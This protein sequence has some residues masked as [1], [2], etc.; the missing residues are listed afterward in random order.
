MKS[1]KKKNRNNGIFRNRDRALHSF[2]YTEDMCIES[3]IFD[4]PKDYDRELLKLR[5]HGKAEGV[6]G[7]EVRA[8]FNFATKGYFSG[9]YHIGDIINFP[10]KE[11]QHKPKFFLNPDD[12]QLYP[13]DE[14]KCKSTVEKRRVIDIEIAYD[15]AKKGKTQIIYILY[16]TEAV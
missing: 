6:L 16:Q 1:F 2:C 12:L 7:F 13:Y 14:L 4:T 15:R 10:R 5:W 9:R 11:Y 8:W 3:L